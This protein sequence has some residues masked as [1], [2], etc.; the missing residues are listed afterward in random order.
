MQKYLDA[1]VR[2][3]RTPIAV[4]LK[5]KS[6]WSLAYY[7]EAFVQAVLYRH[8]IQNTPSLDRWFFVADLDRLSVRAVV[9]F[10]RPDPLTP[11][12]EHEFAV[13]RKVGAMVG[14]DVTFIRESA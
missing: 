1:M 4:E 3:G 2:D 11:T 12:I 10:P 6:E 9:T 7:R 5:A 8:F 13:L 14:V